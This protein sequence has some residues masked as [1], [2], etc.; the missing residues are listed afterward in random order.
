[1]ARIKVKYENDNNFTRIFSSGKIYVL[2]HNNT[3]WEC[4]TVGERMADGNIL[5]KE[6]YENWKSECENEGIFEI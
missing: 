1:M 2:P 5:T 4:V 3:D 6:I